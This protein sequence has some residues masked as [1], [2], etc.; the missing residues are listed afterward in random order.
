MHAYIPDKR[1]RCLLCGP[2]SC[3]SPSLAAETGCEGV[4]LSTVLGAAMRGCPPAHPSLS[5]GSSQLEDLASIAHV[6]EAHSWL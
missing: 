3:R 5:M 2:E 6:L 1:Q 4:M